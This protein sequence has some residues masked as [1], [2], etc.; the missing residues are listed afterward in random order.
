M[1]AE[2]PKQY[3]VLIKLVSNNCAC[4]VGHQIGDE[5][6][7][8]YFTPPHMCGLAFNAIYPFALAL[9]YGAKTPWQKGPDLVTVSCPDADVQ[10]IFELHRREKKTDVKN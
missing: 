7:F 1:E 4:H 10:N 5:C 8:D 3:E 6:V 2:K 9:L